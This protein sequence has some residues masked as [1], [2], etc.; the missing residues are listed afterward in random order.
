MGFGNSPTIPPLFGLGGTLV[1]DPVAKADLLL[2][3]FQNK[4]SLFL[5]LDLKIA[6][7]SLSTGKLIK[8]CDVMELMALP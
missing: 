4:Q 2:E 8:K 3:T 1:S 6:F 7:D 5:F